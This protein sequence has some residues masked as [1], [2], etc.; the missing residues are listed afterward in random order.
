MLQT[1]KTINLNTLVLNKLNV[2]YILIDS[3]MQVLEYSS[4]L[5]QYGYQCPNQGKD[6][7]EDIDFLVGVDA[8]QPLD[9]P[10]VMSPSEKPV[11]ISLVPANGNLI[12][13]IM[14]AAND[15]AQQQSLQQK[16]NEV[17]LLSE[18]QSVLMQQLQA[19]KKELQESNVQ[20]SE[21]SRLQSGF[22]SGVSHEFR[23]PL[24]SIIGYANLLKDIESLN[25]GLVGDYSQAI[26]R[27]S[28]HLLSLVEN[29]LD[30]GRLKSEE[31][32]INPKSVRLAGVISDVLLL[33]TPLA[34][35][36]YLTLDIREN[37]SNDTFVSIDDS[38][39]RQCFINIAANAIKFTD[40]GSVTIDVNHHED[41]LEV[42][43][44]DTGQGI[45]KDQLAK[46]MTPFYQVPDSGK[47][48][49]GL[50]LS[51]TQQLVELM[52][53]KL[54]IDS[55]YG[56]GTTVTMSVIA[57]VEQNQTP[58]S[59]SAVSPQIDKNMNILL[60]EDDQDIAD[61][62]CLLLQQHGVTVT[63]V[64]NGALAVE[65]LTK[66][67]YDLI[68]M[69]V[70]MPVLTGYQAVGAIRQSGVTTPIVIMT[71]SAIEADKAKAQALGCDAYLVKPVDIDDILKIANELTS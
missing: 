15:Y 2:A 36:K 66:E 67:T 14:D 41:M 4:N 51:I 6:V 65:K 24:S 56:K 59:N 22:L 30:H 25:E 68:L 10:V 62:V 23:T 1:S 21:A 60:A 58:I 33:L 44:R 53:G 54:T 37:F 52:G 5:Q 7:T 48:G 28:R 34:E 11:S 38:R 12:V 40:K 71:A 50:G 13:L 16:A 46:V 19:T 64:L 70:H 17:Q 63:H 18:Q 43:V 8:D 49:T 45:Q 61:L 55:V 31:L 29:L 35:T 47:S 57:P 3:H 26:S 69:D 32:V 42:V 27:S 9:L 20:L 39:F